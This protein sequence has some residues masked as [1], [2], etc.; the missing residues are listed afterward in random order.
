VAGAVVPEKL[1]ALSNRIVAASQPLAPHP[2]FLAAI[3]ATST[4]ATGDAQPA[5]L[6]LWPADHAALTD[7]AVYNKAIRS[8]VP[9]KP[10]ASGAAQAVVGPSAAH[11]AEAGGAALA[12][13]AARMAAHNVVFSSSLCDLLQREFASASRGVSDAPNEQQ[14]HDFA[15][16]VS[17]QA[18]SERPDSES[19]DHAAAAGSQGTSYPT[20]QPPPASPLSVAM[21]VAACLL[22]IE[23]GLAS[24][25]LNTL[26]GVP[27]ESAS[28]GLLPKAF[29]EKHNAAPV[30]L[31]SS[32]RTAFDLLRRVLSLAHACPAVANHMATLAPFPAD[33]SDERYCDW[34]V[35]HVRSLAGYASEQIDAK[36]SPPVQLAELRALA[37]S[38]R[39]FG[40]QYFGVEDWASL[41]AMRRPAVKRVVLK[42]QSEQ[43]GLVNLRLVE[44]TD[45]LDTRGTY[46]LWE[47]ENRHALAKAMTVQLRWLST[48]NQFF[49]YNYEFPTSAVKKVVP[50][51]GVTELHR[52]YKVDD[53]LPVKSAFTEWDYSWKL[54]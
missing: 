23:D 39:M 41:G 49:A 40:T 21:D 13:I 34:M 20:Q 31:S 51:G 38:L 26:L 15:C 7:I 42:T 9:H 53:S 25:R 19:A 14:W 22:C 35:A 16:A 28:V 27:L 43:Q 48:A 44:V 50:H 11:S 2:V 46:L 3:E 45:P 52:A 47:M 6:Q 10:M 12:C 29:S 8:G 4:A 33:S 36:K 17:A 30:V 32:N 1:R 18:T 5:L 24:A 37:R 54:V